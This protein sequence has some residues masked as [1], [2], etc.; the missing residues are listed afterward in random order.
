MQGQPVPPAGEGEQTYDLMHVSDAA[1][2]LVLGYQSAV[3]G[4]TIN[5]GTGKDHT[6]DQLVAL[7]VSNGSAAP[8]R[9]PDTKRAMADTCGAKQQLNFAAHANVSEA[10]ATEVRNVLQAKRH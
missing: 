9:P 8:A 7:A 3:H 1:R 2:A 4:I 6:L 10:L 5:A